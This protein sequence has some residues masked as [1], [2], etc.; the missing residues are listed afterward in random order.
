MSKFVSTMR[1]CNLCFIFPGRTGR[2]PWLTQFSAGSV[3]RPS[4][5]S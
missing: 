4:G 1:D 3:R 2:H 5:D